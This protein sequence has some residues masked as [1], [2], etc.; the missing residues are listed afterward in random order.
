MLK[1]V[2]GGKRKILFISEQPG[3]QEDA[4]GRL[5][6]GPISRELREQ[7]EFLGLDFD[8][9]CWLINAVACHNPRGVTSEEIAHCRPLVKKTI[10]QLEPAVIIPM[11]ESALQAILPLAWKD[12]VRTFSRWPGWLIPSRTLNAWIAPVVNPA[13][14]V[15]RRKDR[16]PHCTEL[17]FRSHLAEAFRKRDRPY[18]ESPKISRADEI[19][20]MTDA[21]DISRA[22]NAIVDR[23]GRTAFDYEAT[24]LKPEGPKSKIL[25]CSICWE[26][27][28][29]LAFPWRAGIIEAMERYLFG[30]EC[31]KI[32][33]NIKFEE[34]WTI[35]TF[36]KG[37]RRWEWDTMQTAHILDNR[38]G[39]S[40]IKFLSFVHLGYPDWN[41]HIEP[42][43]ESG[44]KSTYAPNKL[45]DLELKPLLIY[46][47]LD[48]LFEHDVALKQ[49]ELLGWNPDQCSL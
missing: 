45:T 34:R 40:S 5:M 46:N 39:V 10:E 41:S 24:C 13:Y 47:G 11:G 35:W 15:A 3:K 23:G 20:I 1:V 21:V 36:G 17:L 6:R 27:K 16:K 37:V 14:V 7:I 12:D 28:R 44:Q 2:G 31:S 19:T 33:S 49:M 22:I 48:S 8:R 25:T 32:A 9:D 29:T 26:G 43:M 18:Q 42:Y 30:Q 4:D 38:P